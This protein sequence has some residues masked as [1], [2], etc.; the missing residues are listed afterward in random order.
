[1]SDPLDLDAREPMSPERLAAIRERHDNAI[2]VHGEAIAL[3]TSVA[4]DRA[5]LLA[6]VKRRLPVEHVERF[7]KRERDEDVARSLGWHV[8][9]E[10]LDTFRLHV[11]TGTPL[12]EPRPHEGPQVFGEGKEPLTEAEELRAEVERLRGFMVEA[13]EKLEAQKPYEA[14]SLLRE[15][16]YIPA[17]SD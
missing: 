16:L 8:K 6:E 10:V 15:V 3:D 12:T 1:M 5:D 2:W 4:Q 13:F 7:L 11:V 9:D 17:V 14:E